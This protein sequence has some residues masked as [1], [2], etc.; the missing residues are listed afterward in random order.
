MTLGEYK[1]ELAATAKAIARPGKTQETKQDTADS[2][3]PPSLFDLFTYCC[4]A[5]YQMYWYAT[6]S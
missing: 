2:H 3:L 5:A 1:E 4:T 6:Q